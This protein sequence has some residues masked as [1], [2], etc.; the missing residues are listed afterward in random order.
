MAGDTCRSASILDSDINLPFSAKLA[1]WVRLFPA[2]GWYDAGDYNK[3]CGGFTFI[4]RDSLMS[5]TTQ[6]DFS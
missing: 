3:V 5:Y 1:S 6:K 2:G 4:A